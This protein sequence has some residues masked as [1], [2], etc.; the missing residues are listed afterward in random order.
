MQTLFFKEKRL[1]N[2]AIESEETGDHRC[3]QSAGDRLLLYLRCL[4]IGAPR[5]LEL[6][7]K[8]IE[9]A[10]RKT[11]YGPGKGPINESMHAL[12]RLLSEET[13]IL[14]HGGHLPAMRCS[15][16][17]MLP[18]PPVR[19][20]SMRP[21]ELAGRGSLLRGNGKALKVVRRGRVEQRE[22]K[23]GVQPFSGPNLEGGARE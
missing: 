5:A 1:E 14:S 10:K 4:N 20:R 9:E 18:L 19:R 3:W 17:S 13:E 23:A 22:A 11:G 16:A 7:L 6:T 8:A 12:H 2:Q 15:Q 21:Q